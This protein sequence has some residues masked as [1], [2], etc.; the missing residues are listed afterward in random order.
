MV[1]IATKTLALGG[2]HT[3]NRAGATVATRPGAAP[4]A[5]DGVADAD[6]DGG[7][8]L[9]AS[10]PAAAPVLAGLLVETFSSLLS[11]RAR[12]QGAEVVAVQGPIL[13]GA[14]G[15]L[16]GGTVVGSTRMARVVPSPVRAGDGAPVLALATSCV[17]EA[18]GFPTS[19]TRGARVARL[20]H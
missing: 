1:L 11:R 12:R 10:R 13:P 20:L 6:P 14:V 3:L 16:H 4:I 9:L 2:A 15:R 8:T 18:S 17:V 5:R 7:T 19:A